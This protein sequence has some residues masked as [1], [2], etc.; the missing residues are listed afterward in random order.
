MKKLLIL[1]LAGTL[2]NMISLRAQI[3][4]QDL[5]GRLNDRVNTITTD[6]ICSINRLNVYVVINRLGC[7][8]ISFSG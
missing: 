4:T 5:S 3:S 7:L 2:T 1:L 6:I 8:W